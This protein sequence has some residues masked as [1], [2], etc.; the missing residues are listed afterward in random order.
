[1]AD[2]IEVNVTQAAETVA[3][4]ITTP[5]AETVAFTVSDPTEAV[6]LT[7]T[8]GIGPP[9]D[10]WEQTF[11]TVAKNLAAYPV[12][13]SSPVEPLPD[14]MLTT[15]KVLQAPGGTITITKNFDGLTGLP[16]SKVLTGAGLPPG[17]ATTCTYDFSGGR[18]SPLKT[19]T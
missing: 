12:I 2:T 1:M 18:I 16:T 5:T 4:T 9:G 7:V 17:I 3:L 8:D 14:P 11:E 6:A 19:Y 13:S 10:S 15:V